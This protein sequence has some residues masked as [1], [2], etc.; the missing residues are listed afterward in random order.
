M[1]NTKPS[2]PSKS[3]ASV[4]IV[5]MGLAAMCSAADLRSFNTWNQYLGGPDSSQYSGL[6]QINKSNVKQ[7]AVAWTY[8][9]GDSVQY[10]FNPLVVDGV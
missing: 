3:W 8:P 7:L 2:K 5:G 9:T 4:A 1:P 10:L 6:S